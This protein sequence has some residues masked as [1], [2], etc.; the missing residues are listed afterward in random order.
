MTAQNGRSSCPVR[1][2]YCRVNHSVTTHKWD[3]LFQ[4]VLHFIFLLLCSISTSFHHGRVLLLKC[5][6]KALLALGLW[7]IIS[8]VIRSMDTGV[9]LHC[10]SLFCTSLKSGSVR[11]QLQKYVSG[12]SSSKWKFQKNKQ[13]FLKL[14]STKH[15]P[16]RYQETEVND[17]VS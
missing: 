12:S 5:C 13:N 6:N 16:M 7:C 2:L 1:G 17:E 4:F 10:L 9:S 11:L 3:C 8:Q 14:C 15:Y